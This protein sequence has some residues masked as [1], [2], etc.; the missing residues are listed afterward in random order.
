MQK[1]SDPARSVTR[2]VYF[3]V[4]FLAFQILFNAVPAYL[5]YSSAIDYNT[6]GF[7]STAAVSLAFSATAVT[8]LYLVE[9][10]RK[11]VIERLGLGRD[12]LTLGNILIGAFLFLI[13]FALEI[14]VT[15]VS[16]TT[17]VQINTNVSLVFAGAPVWFLLFASVLAPVNEEVLFRGLMVPRLG[18]AASAL[19]FAIPHL[20]YDSTFAI[21]FLAAFVFGLLAG[22]VFKRTNSLYPSVIAH[23]LV[24]TLTLAS[25]FS[26]LI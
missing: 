7:V 17:G 18:V 26:F 22:Y 12:K 3:I 5:Y 2:A 9:K 8:Y 14:V 19:L 1:K 13:I 11:G 15:L 4:I 21:E 25:M 20:T 23:M 16:S 6:L 24:N 10:S